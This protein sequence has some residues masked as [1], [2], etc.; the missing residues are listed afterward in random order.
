MTARH[1]LE[2]PERLPRA[3]RLARVAHVRVVG[4]AREGAGEGDARADLRYT[5]GFALDWAEPAVM[6]EGEA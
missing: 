2:R 1:F 4:V 3:G 5:N 6:G